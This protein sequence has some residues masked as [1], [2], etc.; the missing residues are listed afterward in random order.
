MVRSQFLVFFLVFLAH[1]GIFFL[2]S[3]L[4]SL[5]ISLILV[6]F[7]TDNFLY[8]TVSGTVGRVFDL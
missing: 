4:L 3:A 8:S 2:A 5:L 1:K 7:F 6:F